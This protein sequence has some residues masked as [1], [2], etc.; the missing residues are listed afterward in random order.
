MVKCK[1]YRAVS[2]LYIRVSHK[3]SVY[4][5]WSKQVIVHKAKA[6]MNMV[7]ICPQQR[8]GVAQRNPYAIEVDRGRNYYA[9][10]GFSDPIL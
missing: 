9:C 4:N 7:I 10:S 6:R 5:T 1:E 8:E 2:I 3:K